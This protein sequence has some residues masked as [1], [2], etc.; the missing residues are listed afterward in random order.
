M[1]RSNAKLKSKLA[2]IEKGEITKNPWF[3]NILIY[4]AKKVNRLM[5]FRLDGDCKCAM[6]L[7][8]NVADRNSLI[9]D[10]IGGTCLLIFDTC[11]HHVLLIIL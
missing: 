10:I 11:R 2:I 4:N 7:I 6:T 9:P 1:T 8:A 5:R 3:R